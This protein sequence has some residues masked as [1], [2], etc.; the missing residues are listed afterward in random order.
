MDSTMMIGDD[1]HWTTLRFTI[2][3]RN[4]Y[5]EFGVVKDLSLDILIGGEFV[6]PHECQIIYKASGRDV[7]GMKDGCC[8]KWASNKAQIK[9][10]QDH[11]QQATPKRTPSNRRNLSSVAVPTQ[12][13]DAQE[14]RR[15]KLCKVLADLKIDMIFVSDPIRHQLLSILA[16]RI[17][18]LAVADVDVGHTML[19]E[20]RIETFNSLPFRHM[21]RPVP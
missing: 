15:E 6:R 12:I 8:V 11:Q 3:T 10:E 20:H 16:R 14:R 2:N 18:A 1:H 9:A 5:H 4:A 19:I 7:F 17:D 13:P 21:A